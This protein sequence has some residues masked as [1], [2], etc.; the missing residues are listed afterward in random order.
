MHEIT[1]NDIEIICSHMDTLLGEA[2]GYSKEIDNIL[3]DNFYDFNECLWDL[4][5][6]YLHGMPHH[7]AQ[8][9]M[10]SFIFDTPVSDMTKYLYQNDDSFYWK[11]VVARWRLQTRKL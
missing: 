7:V 4:L 3:D 2:G 5:G 6:S 10:S 8:K 9:E 11:T 1:R